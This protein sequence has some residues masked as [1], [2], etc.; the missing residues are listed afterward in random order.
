MWVGSG[1]FSANDLYVFQ[2]QSTLFSVAEVRK[3]P[4]TYCSLGKM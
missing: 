2:Q 4:V 1:L 3:D